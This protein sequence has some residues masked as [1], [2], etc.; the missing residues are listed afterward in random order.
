MVEDIKRPG[1]LVIDG[2]VAQNWRIWKEEFEIFMRAKEYTRKS[3]EVRVALLLNC[4]GRDARERY[5]HFV[6]DAERGV[7]SYRF[8]LTRDMT[9]SLFSKRIKL[10][11]NRTRQTITTIRANNTHRLYT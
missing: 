6:W 4:I 10:I 1:G 5:N 3:N 7:R 11:Y 2:N 8:F 9:S